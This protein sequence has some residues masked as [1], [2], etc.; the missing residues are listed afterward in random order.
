MKPE[1]EAALAELARVPTLLVALDFDGVLAPIVQDPSTSRPLPGSATA[2]RALAALPATPVAMLSGRGLHD[3]RT[4]S[5]F[6]APVRLIGAALRAEGSCASSTV[7][8]YALRAADP[9]MACQDAGRT[10]YCE[11]RPSRQAGRS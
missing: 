11:D 9:W 5:G 4:V 2:V 6:A 8:E 7:E 1:L 3:L 10:A